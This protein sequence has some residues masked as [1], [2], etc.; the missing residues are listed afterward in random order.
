MGAVLFVSR[1][2]DKELKEVLRRLGSQPVATV[3]ESDHFA[4]G[5]GIFGFFIKENKVRFEVNVDA[6]RR[7]G[8]KISAKLLQVGAVVKD[9]DKR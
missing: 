8:L 9:D 6:A 1:S 7:A 2:L 4:G 5:G 3:G